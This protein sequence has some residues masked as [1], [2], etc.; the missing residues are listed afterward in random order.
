M[1]DND[2]QGV[3][4]EPSLEAKLDNLDDNL[5]PIGEVK[6]K[7]EVDETPEEGKE[8]STSEAEGEESEEE[9]YTIDGDEEESEEPTESSKEESTNNLTAEQKYIIDNLVPIKVR[10]TIGT[11]E[12]VKEYEVYSPEYLPQGFKYVDD[13]E[14]SQANKAFGTLENRALQLQ[15]DYRGQESQKATQEFK[16]REDTADRQD[17]AS[18]QRNGKIPRFKTEPSSSDFEKD[19]GVQLVQEVIDFK[20]AQNARYMTEYNA[21]RP[22]KHIGFD[23]AFRM[24][25]RDNP[26]NKEQES[27]DAARIEQAKRTSKTN[28]STNRSETPKA[29][30]H[31]GMTGMDLDNLIES[32]TMDW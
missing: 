7:E 12:E 23:E 1:A 15:T 29:R 14:L 3:Q 32:R 25:Q 13:R 30:A 22:Y 10:G 21:G 6:E 28:G 20:E 31:S 9:G 26:V 27:E 24:Y 19:P 16:R 17:I 5:N 11:S 2:E 4:L 18:L 8:E